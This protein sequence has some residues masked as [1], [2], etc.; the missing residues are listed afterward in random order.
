MTFFNSSGDNDVFVNI[1]GSR[2]GQSKFHM[3]CSDDDMN[4]D[5]DNDRQ[6]QLPGRSQ[7]CGKFAGNGKDSGGFINDWLA[8][9]ISARDALTDGVHGLWPGNN[10][11]LS[12]GFD[13]LFDASP[14]PSWR[15][16]GR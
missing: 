14:R 2:N 15:A 12:A 3:S 4:A 8:V 1:S 6:A 13:L 7:D 9:R 10:L 16:V 5:N 11:S